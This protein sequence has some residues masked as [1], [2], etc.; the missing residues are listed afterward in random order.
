MNNISSSVHISPPHH[1]ANHNG[2]NSNEKVKKGETHNHSVK[3]GRSVQEQEQT[4]HAPVSNNHKHHKQKG[5]DDIV[6]IQDTDRNALLSNENSNNRTLANNSVKQE[7][8]GH[9]QEQTK[10]T[11]AGNKH[12]HYKRKH[13]DDI[14]RI[15]DRIKNALDSDKTVNN[16]NVNDNLVKQIA[17]V[18]DQ[19]QTKLL[20]GLNRHTH[21]KRINHDDIV[22]ILDTIDN[23]DYSEDKH[24]HRNA[25]NHNDIVHI[26]PKGDN[27]DIV[28]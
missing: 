11:L 12:N 27:I 13:H 16:R 19:E 18:Q 28:I 5:R 10:H 8:R 17:L 21:H 14:V 26:L 9:D 23:I 22:R 25:T 3:H 1:Y 24:N 7:I 2:I 15:Q 4:K 6:R 20:S